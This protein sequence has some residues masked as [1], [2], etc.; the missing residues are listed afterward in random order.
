[1]CIVRSSKRVDISVIVPHFEQAE[2]LRACLRSLDAQTLSKTDFEVIVVDNNSSCDLFD[3]RAEFP[4]FKF[5][6]ESKQGAAHARNAGIDA[7]RGENFAFIDADCTAAPDW[8]ENGLKKL[9]SSPLFGGEIFVTA[10]R[11]KS[12]TPVEAFER[13]FA[14]H[15]RT[16]IERKR[17]SVTANLF[18]TRATVE[19]IGPFHNGIAEDLEWC[20]R[21]AALGFHLAFNDTS[22]VRHP[23]R[24]T[25]D[26][27]V[28]KWERLT[29]ERWNGFGGRSLIRRVRWAGLVV[30]TALSPAPH[31]VSVL[32]SNRVSGWKNKIGAATVLLRIRLWR[33]RRM[34]SLLSPA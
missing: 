13:I 1:M 26:E 18:A 20:H 31:F 14:F 30:A 9:G 23:A 32:F 25:W 15:Q 24:K 7:A 10:E 34:M 27:L 3:I 22:I 17:F 6:S 29:L 21:A 2:L 11:P 16:Y 28:S 19:K 5:L 12:P 4:S 33:A 8:L